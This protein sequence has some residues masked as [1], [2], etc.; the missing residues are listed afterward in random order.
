[1]S[2]AVHPHHAV[3]ARDVPEH[4]LHGGHATTPIVAEDDDWGGGT[5]RVIVLPSYGEVL[6]PGT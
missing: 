2:D 6:C 1:V 5:E 3:R 4:V